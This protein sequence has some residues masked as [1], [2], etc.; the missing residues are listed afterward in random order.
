MNAL[1][2]LRER[3]EQ[4]E[5][6]RRLFENRPN[7]L[8]AGEV[9]THSMIPA[10]QAWSGYK[11]GGGLMVRQPVVKNKLVEKRGNTTLTKEWVDNPIKVSP[12]TGPGS[13]AGKM[14]DIG[15]VRTNTS[16]PMRQKV[17]AQNPARPS[18]QTIRE[19]VSG[20]TQNTPRVTDFQTNVVDRRP[21]TVMPKAVR[22]SGG[23]SM[24]V[25]PG[26]SI[27]EAQ[28]RIFGRGSPE[29]VPRET[30]GGKYNLTLPQHPRTRRWIQDPSTILNIGNLIKGMGRTFQ[31][32][33]DRLERNR[34][35]RLM[36]YRT[37]N[38][39]YATG[40]PYSGGRY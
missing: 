8:R 35:R 19:L 15:P 7:T 38:P 14:L 37:A 40:S 11:P 23:P 39:Y 16:I 17:Q 18:P 2:W 34:I 21:P 30:W 12:G 3:Q 24:E 36:E 5:R 10:S 13:V 31:G 26:E 29:S 4:S 27:E 25:L 1:E 20:Y 32:V 33:D 6:N 9:A 22:A 28:L